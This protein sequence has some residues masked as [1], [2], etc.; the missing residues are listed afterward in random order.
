MEVSPQ[1]EQSQLSQT[2]G[3]KQEFKQVRLDFAGCGPKQFVAE[4]K[5][6]AK[7]SRMGFFNNDE[8]DVN[9]PQNISKDELFHYL[10]AELMNIE[11]KMA[12]LTIRKQKILEMINGINEEISE[13]LDQMKYEHIE[14]EELLLTR[15]S[16]KKIDFST[17]TRKNPEFE[18]S[19][20]NL[21]TYNF[22]AVNYSLFPVL[23]PDSHDGN[24]IGDDNIIEESLVSTQVGGLSLSTQQLK[25]ELKKLKSVGETIDE[26]ELKYLGNQYGIKPDDEV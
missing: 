10:K 4:K 11:N 13:K 20:L 14:L 26:T 16:F 25:S 2:V 7:N 17:S 21:A 18:H 22:N 3:R 15:D 5:K 12:Q 23:D 1:S 6:R 8:L 9:L 24:S 19:L